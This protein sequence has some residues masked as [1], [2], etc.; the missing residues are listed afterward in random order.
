MVFV[1]T[2]TSVRITYDTDKNN[3]NIQERGLSFELVYDLDWT[4]SIFDEDT[5]K[6]YGERRLYVLAMLG[7]RLHAVIITYR[8]DAV[9]IISFRKANRREIVSYDS[10]KEKT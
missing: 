4:T 9:H 7:D 10:I 3:R 1:A 8:D 2:N 5:R 6:D